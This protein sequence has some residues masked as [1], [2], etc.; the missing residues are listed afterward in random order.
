MASCG[1]AANHARS[2]TL[3]SNLTFAAYVS[4]SNRKT[5][6]LRSISF[7]IPATRATFQGC[8]DCLMALH[9]Q[10]LEALKLCV[11]IHSFSHRYRP[12]TGFSDHTDMYYTFDPS[13]TGGLCWN[14]YIG[15]FLAHHFRHSLTFHDCIFVD[16]SC[17]S[18][19]PTERIDASHGQDKISVF[20]TAM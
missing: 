4:R 14:S 9:G 19:H 17:F 8:H 3:V 10:G 6:F 16:I 20:N 18:E 7:T 5:T 11:T 13:T 2:R 15:H 12:R 1:T